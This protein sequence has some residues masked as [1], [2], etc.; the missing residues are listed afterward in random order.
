[1]SVVIEII[2]IYLM[3][4]RRHR[5]RYFNWSWNCHLLCGEWLVATFI[6]VFDL[7]EQ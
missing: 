7:L 1:M 5:V 3:T 6:H 4:N 2:N